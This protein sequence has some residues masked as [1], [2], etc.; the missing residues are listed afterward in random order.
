MPAVA[1]TL[2]ANRLATKEA[3]IPFRFGATIDHAWSRTMCSLVMLRSTLTACV[4]TSTT[5]GSLGWPLRV[6]VP[7]P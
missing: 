4:E 5:R 1:V 7:A 2:A 6:T 3:G